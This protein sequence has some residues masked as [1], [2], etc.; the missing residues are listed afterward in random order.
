MCKLQSY[1]EWSWCDARRCVLCL[2]KE[3]N[4][5][6]EEFYW[7]THPTVWDS[8]CLYSVWNAWAIEIYRMTLR[9]NEAAYVNLVYEM[10]EKQIC[11]NRPGRR[12][13]TPNVCFA[14]GS[15]FVP[16]YPADGE[17]I[18]YLMFWNATGDRPIQND[19]WNGSISPMPGRHNYTELN[20][21]N[22]Q[23][24]LFSQKWR[25][26]SHLLIHAQSQIVK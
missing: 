11:I 14:R 1:P 9:R 13:E 10:R 22:V 23:L 18:C 16:I 7:T 4:A 5:R 21:C 20:A 25:Q 8:L 2:F 19:L 24:H 17:I 12:C 15:Y 3:R 6:A 26:H